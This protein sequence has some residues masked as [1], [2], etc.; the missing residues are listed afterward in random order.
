[1]TSS[2]PSNMHLCECMGIKW[3]QHT[4]VA[5][6]ETPYIHTGITNTIPTNKRR[7]GGRYISPI[8]SSFVS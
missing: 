5:L 2:E 4:N 8:Y 1:M 6:N 7:D 3:R